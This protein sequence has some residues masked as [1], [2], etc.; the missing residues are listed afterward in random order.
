MPLFSGKSQDWTR[1]SLA[2][3]QIPR[4]GRDTPA[5][6]QRRRRV[7]HVVHN[8]DPSYIYPCQG[9]KTEE[10]LP[11]LHPYTAVQSYP[12]HHPDPNR[13][14]SQGRPSTE[15]LWTDT[16]G[17]ASSCSGGWPCLVFGLLQSLK[18]VVH[19][20]DPSY[21]MV[22]YSHVFPVL[23][24]PVMVPNASA[25][26]M[27]HTSVW[28]SIATCHDICSYC[29]VVYGLRR[30]RYTGSVRASLKTKMQVVHYIK[31]CMA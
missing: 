7:K 22:S 1:G 19:N 18:H 13:N 25:H 5:R 29:T 10:G 21:R 14:E 9:S 28:L 31:P 30:P 24:P 11:E 20:H 27:Q 17:Q 16:A 6:A 8:H 23:S 12:N 15:E 2:S 26:P 4:C 3:L